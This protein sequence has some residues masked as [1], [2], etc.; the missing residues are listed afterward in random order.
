MRQ[1]AIEGAMSLVLG[2]FAVL[3]AAWPEWIE[4]KYGVSP[5]GGNGSLEWAVVLAL[6]C[7]ALVAGLMARRSMRHANRAA[8]GS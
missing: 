5:D 8:V 1:S 4:A 3:T 6:G 2:S 7:G